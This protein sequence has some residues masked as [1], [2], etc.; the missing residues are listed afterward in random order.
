[1][2]MQQKYFS[3][4]LLEADAPKGLEDLQLDRDEVYTQNTTFY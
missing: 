3:G 4:V 2:K 1:M